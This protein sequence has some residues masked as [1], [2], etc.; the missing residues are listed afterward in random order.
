MK[1]EY[2][3]DYRTRRSAYRIRDAAR[4]AWAEY[5]DDP[6]AHDPR[7]LALLLILFRAQG[8]VD[9]AQEVSLVIAAEGACAP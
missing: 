2:Q 5:K 7:L 8:D 6:E 3:N 4:K 1:L 9:L